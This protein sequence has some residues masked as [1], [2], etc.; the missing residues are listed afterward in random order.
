[1]ANILTDMAK[2]GEFLREYGKKNF[3]VVR[4]ALAIDRVM[5]S[6]IPIGNGGKYAADFYLTTTQFMQLTDEIKRGVFAKKIAADKGQYPAAYKFVTGENGDKH[7]NIGGGDLGVRIQVVDNTHNY[8]YIMAVAMTAIDA[9]AR[10]FYLFTGLQPVSAGSFFGS[11]ISLFNDGIGEREK[12]RKTLSKEDSVAETTAS[13]ESEPEK[14]AEDVKKKEQEPEIMAFALQVQ[15]APTEKNGFLYFPAKDGEEDVS[16]MF[17]KEVTEKLCWFERFLQQA[18]S[19]GI[20]SFRLNGQK[21]NGYILF[22]SAA[23]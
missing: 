18:S 11:L 22:D 17:R 8:R 1:M 9:M 12:F 19:S 3:C 13:D 23:K 6:I 16:L 21:K 4:E 14:T 15:G 7:L 2:N 10:N 5:V 20:N